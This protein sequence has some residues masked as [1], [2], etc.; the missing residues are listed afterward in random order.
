MNSDDTWICP[1][2]GLELKVGISG[3]PKCRPKP[4]RRKKP[5]AKQARQSWEQDPS[6]DG[7]DLPDEDFDYDEYVAREFGNQ[8]HKK[9]GIAWYWWVTGMVLLI[10]MFWSF[11][12][13][14]GFG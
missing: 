14:S 4:K 12:G 3:C 13:F 8:P 6:Y 11:G 2:C 10:V 1:G 7:L 9:L 5:K